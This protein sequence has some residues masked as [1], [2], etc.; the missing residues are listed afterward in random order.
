MIFIK[1]LHNNWL[2]SVFESPGKP[3]PVDDYMPRAQI[4][5]YV[6]EGKLATA[7]EIAEFFEAFVVSEE[8]VKNYI[9]HLK[10]LSYCKNLRTQ[11]T[12]PK[13]RAR[14]SKNYGDYNWEELLLTE[15]LNSL[16]VSELDLYLKNHSLPWKKNRASVMCCT[17]VSIA[18]WLSIFLHYVFCVLK[19]EAIWWA[20]FIF[21][22]LTLP[23]KL[24]ERHNSLRQLLWP[25]FLPF[26]PWYTTENRPQHRELRALLLTSFV[27]NKLK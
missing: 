8:L 12:V 6:A 16:Y 19:F 1:P 20:Y 4:K 18:C 27:S 10:H 7:K 14:A 22:L 15:G 23:V 26:Q 3:R 21:I 17:R 13:R 24:A 9:D 2:Q 11:E 5:K 25:L